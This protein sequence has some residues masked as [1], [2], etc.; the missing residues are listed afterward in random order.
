[1][2]TKRIHFGRGWT[3][4]PPPERC[5]LC[6][7]KLVPVT[8]IVEPR[9]NVF[10][11][12]SVKVTKADRS[13]LTYGDLA[14]HLWT[15]HNKKGV[16]SCVCGF[17]PSEIP[18]IFTLQALG[19]HLCALGAELETHLLFYSLGETSGNGAREA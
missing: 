19:E 4:T 1:M 5:L 3:A 11:S 13:Y 15:A 14:V 6:R 9:R 2:R 8:V 12:L 16:C 7:V 17:T 18:S 10:G